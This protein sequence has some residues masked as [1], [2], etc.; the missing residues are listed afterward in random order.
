MSDAAPRT[1]EMLKQD[2]LE[3]MVRS[4]NDDAPRARAHGLDTDLPLDW[5]YQSG[6]KGLPNF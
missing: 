4:A 1:K 6:T 3:Y 5:D 2:I